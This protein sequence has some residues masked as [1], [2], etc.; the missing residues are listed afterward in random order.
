MFCD[1]VGS[2][3]LSGKLDLEDLRE[4]IGEYHRRVTE[5]VARFSGFVAKYMGD[6]VLAYFGYPQAHENDAERAVRT[7]LSLIEVIGQL[8]T[9]DRLHVRIGIDTGLV[10]VGDLV[11]SGEAQERGIVGQ[12]PNLAARLQVLA[13]PDTVVIGPQTRRLLGNLFEYHDLGT[14]EVKGFSEPVSAYQVLRLSTIESRFEALHGAALTPLV[15]REEEIDLLLRR[16]QRAMSGDGQVVLMS[17]EPGIGKSRLTAAFQDRVA[18]E[19]HR[20][21]RYFCSPHY[22]DSALHPVTAQ[23]ERAAEFER[24]DAA[25]IRLDK[26]EALLAQ[27]VPPAEDAALLA[28]LLSLPVAG[29]Y[30][31]LNL[32][33]QR[34]KEETFNALLRR[35]EGLA[36]QRLV[37]MVFEDVHWSDPTTRELLDRMVERVR[38]LPILLVVTF[39]PEFQPPWTGQAHVTMLTLNRLSRRE[40]TT[41]AKGIAGENE[42]PSDLLAKIVERTD[43]VPLFVEELTK[44]VL[45]AHATGAHGGRTVAGVLSA[46]SAVPATLHAS[47]MA[48]LDRLSATAKEVAQIG[49]A[50]GREFSYEL[51]ADVSPLPDSALQDALHQLVASGLVLQRGTPPEASYL[52]KHALIQDAAYGTLLRSRRQEGHARIAAALEKRLPDTAAARPELLAHHLTEAGRPAQAVDYWIA[53]GNRALRRAAH[54]EASAFYERALAALA[55]Q[56][57]TSDTLT[58]IIDLRRQLHQALYPLGRFQHARANL[59]E[60]ERV[61]ERLGDAVRLSRVLSSQIYLLS[62]TGD[63][64]GAVATGERALSLL[65]ERDDLDAAVNTRLM[66]ARALYA[67][68]RYGEALYRARE[69]VALL[70]ED[71]ERGAMAGLNQTVSVRVWLTLFHAERGEF[72]A[73]A[74][75]GDIAMR[76]AVQPRCSEHEVLWS[77]LGV[78]R[79]Q[80]V[81]GDLVGAIETLTPA[82]PLCKGDLTIYFP[83]VAS[84]LGAAYAGTGRIDEGIVLLQQADEHARVIGHVFGHALVLAQFGR[85]LL[86]TGDLDRAQ[87]VGLRALEA[88]QRWGERG[89]EAWV[90]CLLGDVASARGER[91]EAQTDYREALAIADH[92]EMAP[93]RARCSEGLTRLASV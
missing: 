7:G 44:T 62:A 13:K 76:L 1:L 2:T 63:L 4:V 69:V 80:V 67:A 47:L 11:G 71:I 84:S 41:L 48:R 57:E 20:L 77:R 56:E 23:L 91:R 34:M 49:A 70:G 68:G 88:A 61:A 29:R 16:W 19:P 3:A 18:H 35:L 31:P 33:P 45:D 66:L 14:V 9:P 51:L 93:V 38:D 17:G 5:T 60:A 50:I 39:R 79:L 83:R 74:A 10:V 64:A 46:T 85:A 81:R 22:Q 53:A 12:T 43:G 42:L 21:L 28:E 78:G 59:I 24:E 86:L 72:E 89:N 32:T 75:E 73:G 30:S 15:D 58:V 54:Q 52:Y 8:Q 26:L 36:R 90:R 55:A 92:L 27:T 65:A 25:E 40:G 37:L 82:L 6:G 87:E